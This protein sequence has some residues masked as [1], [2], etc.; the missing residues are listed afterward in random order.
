MMKEKVNEVL[1]K[2]RGMLYADGG[3]IE[4]VDVDEKEGIVK[5]RLTGACMGCPMSSQTL[6]NG[7]EKMLKEEIPEIKSV[8]SV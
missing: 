5:V 2:I 7:V 1:D 8:V 6:K 4:L 3:N